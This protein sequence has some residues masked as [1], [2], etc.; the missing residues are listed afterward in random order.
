MLKFDTRDG[1]TVSIRPAKLEDAPTLQ[2]NCLS[3]NTLEEVE[4]FL[5]S[6]IEA[7]D[8]G[9]KVRL[10]AD[11]EGEAVGNLEL[12]FSHHPLEFHKA[13]IGTMVV[14]PKFRRRVIALKL[15]ETALKIAKER[16]LEIVKL[17]VE[18]TNVP[19]VKLYTKAGFEEYGRLKRGIVSS[20]VYYDQILLKKDL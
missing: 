9:D 11:V 6:D 10:I 8:K 1:I 18:A 14:N 16:H 3:G 15:I 7:M 20:G 4:N 17:S 2:N 12:I 13:E 19:A 5:K